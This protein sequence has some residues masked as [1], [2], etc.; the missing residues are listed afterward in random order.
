VRSY[1]TTMN[2]SGVDTTM[3][4]Q[5]YIAKQILP[6]GMNHS[7]HGVIRGHSGTRQPDRVLTPKS[8]ANQPHEPLA[9]LHRKV[10][11]VEELLHNAIAGILRHG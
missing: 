2:L 4:G 11:K 1:N 5:T 9:V 10:L 7:A 3:D 6:A 8:V